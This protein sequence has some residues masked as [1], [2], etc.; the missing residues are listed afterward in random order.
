M[1]LGIGC[2]DCRLSAYDVPCDVTDKITYF[3]KWLIHDDSL[4]QSIPA[5]VEGWKWDSECM[6]VKQRPD[7]NRIL[8]IAS[9]T[10]NDEFDQVGADLYSRKDELEFLMK[11]TAIRDSY[12]SEVA[13]WVLK[14]GSK[15]TR[16]GP[17]STRE[18]VPSCEDLR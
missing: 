1:F 16:Y 11:D 10:W 17:F 8:N 6:I 4:S 15:V 5:T 9:M 3:E 18:A 7:T 14:L 2:N 13:Y 12:D